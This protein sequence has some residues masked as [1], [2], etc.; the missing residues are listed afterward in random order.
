VDPLEGFI[1]AARE[2]RSDTGF[3]LDFD[4]TLSLIAPTP[5]EATAVPGAPE[6]L[7][8]LAARYGLTAVLSGRRTDALR[9]LIPAEGVEYVGLYGAE[10]H[11]TA[12][13]ASVIAALAADAQAFI[14]REALEGV[15]V[16]DKAD[17]VAIHYRLAASPAA[18]AVVTEWAFDRA[19]DFGLQARP[20]KMVVELIPPGPTKGDAV[21]ALIARNRLRRV[22]VAGDDVSDV[23]SLRRA[24]ELLGP[25]ALRVGVASAEEP[26]GLADV[27]DLMVPGPPA[28][29]DL[30]ARFV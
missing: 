1:A 19:A 25:E 20:G 10:D 14:A 12:V 5:E 15:R 27:A 13:P 23:A 9:R 16:E 22:L 26:A 24:G 7:A 28:V 29:L 30:L 11:L 6:M 18:G 8:A 21:E 3:V 4:G 2:G 17:S